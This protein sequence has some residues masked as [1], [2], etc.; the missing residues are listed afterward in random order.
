MEGVLKE[1]FRK[2]A[3]AD[4]LHEESSDR[5][6]AASEQ[7][8]GRCRC[9]VFSGLTFSVSTPP[10]RHGDGFLAARAHTSNSVADGET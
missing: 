2:A 5:A 10:P 6:L 7:R 8:F 9:R 3:I 1:I 4:H